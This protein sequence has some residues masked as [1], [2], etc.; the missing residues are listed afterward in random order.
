M[1]KEIINQIIF[2]CASVILVVLGI[3]IYDY[4][5]R[6]GV[7]E[8][9]E[10][11]KING[12]YAIEGIMRLNKP[13]ICKFEKS[14]QTSTI[15]GVLHTDGKNILGEFRIKTDLQGS[16]FNSFLV[17]KNKDAY[18]WTSLQNVGFKTLVAKNASK[19]ASPAEQAQIVGLRDKI[20]YECEPWQNPD[21]TIFETPSYINFLDLK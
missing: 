10:E 1:K 2:I 11:E 19:N 8:I 20:K 14:D 12:E 16:E 4:M 9:G 21:S 5:G 7:P 18:I 17:I 15:A 13:Y 3:Y 6:P